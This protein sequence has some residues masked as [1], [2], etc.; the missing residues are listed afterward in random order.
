MMNGNIYQKIYDLLSSVLPNKWDKLVFYIE[1]VDN[2]YQMKFFTKTGR[3]KYLDCFQTV[4]D[5]KK[6]MLVFNSIHQA[7]YPERNKLSKKEKWTVLTYILTSDGDFN[8]YFDYSDH[9]N[10]MIGWETDWMKSYLK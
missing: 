3:N 6:L 1:Y 5:T 8:T 9:H 10:N 4:K 2:S 7:V